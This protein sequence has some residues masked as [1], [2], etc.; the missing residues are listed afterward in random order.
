MLFASE[1]SRSVSD[2]LTVDSALKPHLGVLL[3]GVALA[4]RAE[5]Y[6]QAARLRGAVVKLSEDGEFIHHEPFWNTL[7][8]GL[9]DVLGQQTWQQEQ[10][11]GAAM[12][13]DETVALARSLAA[14]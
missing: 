4:S 10:E 14:S 2:D 8:Q 3:S 13:F 1:L 12:T 9:I 11:A 7:D 5:L 6:P